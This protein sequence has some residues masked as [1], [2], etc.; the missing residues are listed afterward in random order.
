MHQIKVKFLD[1]EIDYQLDKM[2]TPLKFALK[3]AL[4]F[5]IFIL[6]L[7]NFFTTKFIMQIEWD[8]KNRKKFWFFENIMQ[9]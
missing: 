6:I 2:E 1:I 9:A 8:R 7:F 4:V 3:G 5:I